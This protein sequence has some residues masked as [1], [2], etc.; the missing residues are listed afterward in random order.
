MRLMWAVDHALQTRSKRMEASLGV[1]SPQRLVLR[2]V[3]RFPSMPAGQIARI[4]S[5]HPSTLTGILKRLE[6]RGLLER[7]EDPKDARRVLLALTP[8]GKKIDQQREGTVENAVR[9]VLAELPGSQ[10]SAARTALSKLAAAL[11]EPT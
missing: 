8:R 7:R 5:L 9:A 1:T 2:I 10:L 4:L 6:I 3:G 11:E